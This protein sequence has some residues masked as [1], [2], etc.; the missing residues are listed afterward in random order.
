MKRTTRDDNILLSRNNRSILDIY[1]GGNSSIYL[2]AQS[3]I[4][5]T[6]DFLHQESFPHKQTSPTTSQSRTNST[7]G[8]LLRFTALGSFA[9]GKPST[10]SIMKI[11]VRNPESHGASDMSFTEKWEQV[12]LACSEDAQSKGFTA[13]LLHDWN[14]DD[15][16]HFAEYVII[17][18]K[19][20]IWCISKQAIFNN[21]SLKYTLCTEKDIL[22]IILNL[23]L[24]YWTK[25]RLLD[26][27]IK[28]TPRYLEFTIVSEDLP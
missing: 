27:E 6:S 8:K 19:S 20:Q 22:V 28:W 18:I 2:K 7:T 9:D 17:D 13:R 16:V 11:R 5:Q 21:A 24:C 15:I 26:K 3:E 12:W 25:L 23:S 14:P 10:A 1:K 4:P